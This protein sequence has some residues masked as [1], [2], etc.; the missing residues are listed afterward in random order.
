[1]E[2]NIY[3]YMGAEI[4]NLALKEKGIC[5]FKCSYPKD[6]N[7]PYELFLTVDFQ[8][9]PEMLA[10]YKDAVGKL[11]QLPTTCFSKSPSVI[12]MWAHY[13]HGHRGIVLEFNETAFSERFPDIGFGDVDYLDTASEDL[14]EILARACHIGKPRYYYLLRKGVFSTAYYSKHTHWSYE[15]ERRLVAGE[16]DV[17]VVGDLMLLEFPVECI[18]SIIVGNKASEEIKKLAYEKAQEI[19]SSY[20]EI[21]ISKISIDPYYID[22]DGARY[23]F[24][25][26]SIQKCQ[27]ICESCGEPVPEGI[28]ICS[29]CAIEEH[30]VED[31]YSSNPLRILQRIGHLDDYIK[32][33]DKVG[34]S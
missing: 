24:N 11:P 15:Q 2:S 29:W 6:F 4:F 26:W 12:P 5:S 7:D 16:D 10:T 34:K 18:S 31:A 21:Q 19:G 20:Y 22:K 3:K 32:E 33:M 13:A 23:A 8:Q 27:H 30:H 9:S 17:K 1:M 14:L 25:E 28:E